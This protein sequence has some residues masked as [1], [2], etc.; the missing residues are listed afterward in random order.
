MTFFLN[1]L[2]GGWSPK[3]RAAVD[4]L[5][6]G[7]A[8]A[9]YM[10]MRFLS[11]NHGAAFGF[12]DQA[13]LENLDHPGGFIGTILGTVM[14]WL[15]YLKLWIWPHPLSAFHVLSMPTGEGEWLGFSGALF[16]AVGA[17]VAAIRVRFLKTAWLWFFVFIFPVLN[18]IPIGGMF[19]ERH[20]YLPSM[21]L[22]WI[23][24]WLIDF[25]VNRF[26]KTPLAVAVKVSAAGVVVA[27]ALISMGY[28]SA[29][30]SDDAL[31]R[32]AHRLYPHSADP[33]NKMAKAFYDAGDLM[34]AADYYARAAE[35]EK[36]P[37]KEI[38]H[39]RKA[40]QAFGLK[41]RFDLA[42]Q[43][44]QLL[45]KLAPG[46]E[47]IRFEWGWT[48][49]LSG[50][51][52]QAEAVYLDL[53]ARFPDSAR[54]YYGLSEV[55]FRRGQLEAGRRRSMEALERKPNEALTQRILSNLNGLS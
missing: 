48:Y 21:A 55:S 38:E 24:A 40:A 19:N 51:L 23:C 26:S 47:V 35:L 33:L 29:W 45:V 25:C 1:D 13:T 37:Q 46:D 4:L 10:G 52:D 7:F 42:L 2:S 41:S 6:W 30:L 18:I 17:V 3:W 34:S 14:T 43:Q 16:L 44:Y 31:W 28:A 22:A 12:W 27:Y 15:G 54:G 8:A 9:L 32:R 39:R 36:Y 53:L 11:V 49:F 20:L 50:G 5:P